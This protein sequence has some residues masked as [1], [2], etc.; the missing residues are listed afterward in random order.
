MEWSLARQ[1]RSFRLR[2]RTKPGAAPGT[3]VASRNAAATS[4]DL[5][6][7]GAAEIIEID[8]VDFASLTQLRDK[9]PAVW[10]NVVGLNDIELIQKVGEEFG[11][12][13]LAL[14][15]VLNVH[16]RAKFEDFEGHLFL[17]ARMVQPNGPIDTEQITM[18]LGENFLLT[19]QEQPGDSFEP[20]RK[21]L[22]DGIGRI[23]TAPV[24]YLCY[25]LIDAV[26]DG[27]FPVLE[28]LGEAL[29]GLERRIVDNTDASIMTDLHDFKRELIT[30]R[31]PIWQHRELTNAIA[32][33]GAEFF[34]DTTRVYVRDIYDHVIQQMDLVEIYREI[35]S[36]LVDVHISSASAKLNEV[37]KVLAT[38]AT[39]FLPLTFIV[40]LYGMNFDPNVSPWNMPE[41]RWY[42]GYPFALSVMVGAVAG[43]IWYFNRKGWI[44]I[45]HRKKR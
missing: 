7:Y 8:N 13:S 40:G 28:R 42:L 36:G 25:A 34:T 37:M 24:D 2:R 15:D 11:L 35:A 10:I 23:R 43:M 20:V 12:H 27:Y 32:R 18:F 16:Q 22:H 29:D 14:E 30:L 33:D 19:F 1:R 39:V 41:L 44:D 5:I 4:I 9:Y 45:L 17:V 31:H 3:L 26:I 6:A 21:R 38:I